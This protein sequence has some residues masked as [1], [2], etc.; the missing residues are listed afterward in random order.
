MFVVQYKMAA[1][2]SS[3][4]GAMHRSG[5]PP[6]GVYS[7]MP[8]PQ[9]RDP[10]YAAAYVPTSQQQPSSQ[11]SNNPVDYYTAHYK[12]I[13]RA[14]MAGLD[15]GDSHPSTTRSQRLNVRVLP[16]LPSAGLWFAVAS[17]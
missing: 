3:Q 8:R 4:N 2:G 9:S 11:N 17:E 12:S 6:S 1:P 16:L 14:A 7:S 5:L 15:T 10:H 13:P